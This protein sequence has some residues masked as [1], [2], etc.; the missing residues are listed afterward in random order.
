MTENVASSSVVQSD[1]TTSGGTANSL[2]RVTV[3]VAA[4]AL[5]LAFFGTS[6][7]SALARPTPQIVVS[8]STGASAVVTEAYPSGVATTASRVRELHRRSGLTWEQLARLFRADRRTIHLWASGRPMRAAQIDRLSKLAEAVLRFDRGSSTATR[9]FLLTAKID[10]KS[11]IE[12]IEEEKFGDLAAAMPMA[13]PPNRWNRMRRP[14]KLSPAATRA[15]RGFSLP[16][17]LG[18]E[19]E[20]DVG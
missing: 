14:P 3:T 20:E 19:D 10:G 4:G 13:A 16:E 9:D 7:V 8:G 5:A 2:Q 6:S 15:R 1:S 11:V 12:L 18:G 17:L